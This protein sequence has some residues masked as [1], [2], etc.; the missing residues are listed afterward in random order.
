MNMAKEVD[1]DIF[2]SIIID[3]LF[4]RPCSYGIEVFDALGKGHTRHIRSISRDE[5]DISKYM[6]LGTMLVDD[7]TRILSNMEEIESRC[8]IFVPDNETN[9]ALRKCLYDVILW[10]NPKY[11]ISS[12]TK[13]NAMHCLLATFQDT[14]VLGIPG[15]KTYSTTMSTVSTGR[16]VIMQQL[17]SSNVALGVPGY[18]TFADIARWMLLDERS[19]AQTSA[20]LDLLDG[21]A[22]FA[23]WLKDDDG[24]SDSVHDLVTAQIIWL[25]RILRRFRRL[26]D[27]YVNSTGT[28]IY[29]LDCEPFVWPELQTFR[30]PLLGRLSFFKK[31]EAVGNSDSLRSAR[32]ADFCG[33]TEK[34]PDKFRLCFTGY[35]EHVS[36]VRK[37]KSLLACFDVIP[38]EA[39]T[40]DVPLQLL[41]DMLSVNTFKEYILVEDS[42]EV[43][44]TVRWKIIERILTRILL[45]GIL[46]AIRFPD[47]R[48]RASQKVNDTITL[49][50][51]H[52]I[53]E[54]G[55]S[56][57]LQGY[58]KPLGLKRGSYYRL[59]KR[60]IDFNSDKVL[61]ALK[62]MD[63]LGRETTF[64][65][66]TKFYEL[67]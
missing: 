57:A 11:S 36:P 38:E 50:N 28:D 58:F 16:V 30:S 37:V 9:R 43:R 14:Q 24:K 44:S 47:L 13:E 12:A 54:N 59:Y 18:Y 64:E 45:Q 65:V 49:V 8:A 3:P 6:E 25:H 41:T 66:S 33:D 53:N 34:S 1:H 17:I 60:Y 55:L 61:T 5:G 15:V 26:A 22:I 35:K 63:E 29:C 21:K 4:L 10:S 51:V 19:E 39:G 7:L 62:Q 56:L 32:I 23:H 40:N 31:L 46:E 52:H 20:A 2:L 48:Y 67:M 42:P 27:D